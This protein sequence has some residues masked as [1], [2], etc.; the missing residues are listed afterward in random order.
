MTPPG[1]AP[2]RVLASPFVVDGR[3]SAQ[4]APPPVL[5]EHTR[6]VLHRWLGADDADVAALAAAGAFGD[7]VVR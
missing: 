4:T 5:G 1:M 3:R 2:V 6:Q 7:F